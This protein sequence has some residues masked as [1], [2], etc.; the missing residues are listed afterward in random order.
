MCVSST[1]ERILTRIQACITDYR[2]GSVM[3]GKCIRNMQMSGKGSCKFHNKDDS[4]DFLN[5]STALYCVC[6]IQYEC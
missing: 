5:T 1:N 4:L 2:Y 6:K 3:V